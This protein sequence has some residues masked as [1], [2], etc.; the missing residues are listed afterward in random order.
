MCDIW[1]TRLVCNAFEVVQLEGE[2]MVC[3]FT[4]RNNVA[5]P[6]LN[7]K[8]Q[9]PTGLQYKFPR[10]GRH[11]VGSVPLQDQVVGTKK[12]PGRDE[13]VRGSRTGE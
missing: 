6:L 5:V 12:K 8:T 3:W 1:R 10:A 11:L 2:G 13:V 4:W 9:V 7:S